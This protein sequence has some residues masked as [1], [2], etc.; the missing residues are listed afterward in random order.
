[1]VAE[2]RA[3]RLGEISHYVHTRERR[4]GGYFA[5]ATRAEAEAFVGADRAKQ[6]MTK[7]MLARYTLDNQATVD[8]WLPQVQERRLYD[9]INHL[10]SYRN[11]Y[12]ASTHGKTSAEWI[13]SHWQS[14]A[15]GRD[16][17]TT[18][19]FTAC[20]NCSTQPSVILTIRGA[21]LPNEV[22]VL[23]AHLDSINANTYTGGAHIAQ[24]PPQAAHGEQHA[25]GQAARQQAERAVDEDRRIEALGDVQA[26]GLEFLLAHV[27]DD[28]L[29]VVQCVE[30]VGA[31]FAQ[32]AQSDRRG[33]AS[34][35][36]DGDAAPWRLLAPQATRWLRPCRS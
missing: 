4:C 28:L 30:H 26:Q 23:G 20:A 22:V 33:L 12:Y 16:D 34:C 17:A 24:E 6:A 18:E 11:R 3:D 7:A 1:M 21:E 15:A 10:S 36:V 8:R 14:I 13:R 25:R 27:G 29:H 32:D 9:T 2:T 31:A 35:S 5:F 19:L